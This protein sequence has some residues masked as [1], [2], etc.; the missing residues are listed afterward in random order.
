MLDYKDASKLH[1]EPTTYAHFISWSYPCWR[2]KSGL[3][4]MAMK[5]GC[6]A[7]LADWLKST[8]DL[9]IDQDALIDIQTLG[10]LELNAHLAGFSS[11]F[12]QGP[13]GS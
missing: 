3:R 2:S 6:K 5:N 1:D 10:I 9:E 7:K 11:A 12:H 13:R 8:M 4:W